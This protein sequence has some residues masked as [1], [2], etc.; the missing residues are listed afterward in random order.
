MSS[1]VPFP[2]PPQGMASS[3]VEP[4][5]AQGRLQAAADEAR[6]L[7]VVVELVRQSTQVDVSHYKDSTFR[8]QLQRRLREL[9]EPDLGQYVERLAR[10]PAELER[11]QQSLLISVTR[12]FRDPEVFERLRTVLAEVVGGKL[13][14]HP[15]PPVCHRHRPAGHLPCAPRGLSLGGPGRCADR[16][17]QPLLRA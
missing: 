9:G 3:T 5:Q 1:S 2:L 17:G 8:R 6:L 16:T 11:L 15:C 13:A 7:G 4:M 14:P 10:D 12:F